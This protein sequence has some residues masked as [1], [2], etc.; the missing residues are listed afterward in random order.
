[1]E[2]VLPA[3]ALSSATAKALRGS[4]P[5]VLTNWLPP[6]SMFWDA[7]RTLHELDVGGYFGASTAEAHG[8]WP[9]LLQVRSAEL[10]LCTSSAHAN[11]CCW[12]VCLCCRAAQLA[13]T[14]FFE[15]ALA[16]AALR[17]LL[18]FHFC[19]SIIT[20][21][22]LCT[23]QGFWW[24]QEGS[25][26]SKS[27][28]AR[29]ER[30]LFQDVITQHQSWHATLTRVGPQALAEGGAESSKVALSALGG[31]VSYMRSC[32]LD[33][34]VLPLRRFAPLPNCTAVPS[35]VSDV[36]TLRPDTVSLDGSAFDN[37]EVGCTA[38][39]RAAL[40]ATTGL[41]VSLVRWGRR[42]C[43]C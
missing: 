37:L 30:P 34:S 13:A 40:A 32:L 19:F 10:C 16:H 20:V 26:E 11:P 35:A 18:I 43:C 23:K 17:L 42:V 4:L 24:L 39:H 25:A 7:K 3:G 36:E 28:H 27:E 21:S 9:P 2:L 15:T 29:F 6:G 1:M 12:A 22:V 5:G 33:K 14:Q 31:A 38:A 41:P 8:G